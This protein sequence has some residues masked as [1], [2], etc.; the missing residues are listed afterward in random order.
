MSQLKFNMIGIKKIMLKK[1]NYV[2]FEKKDIFHRVLI[3]NRRGHLYFFYK[4]K[5][6]RKNYQSISKQIGAC[7]LTGRSRSIINICYLKRQIFKRICMENKIPM[8]LKKK[9]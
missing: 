9:K 4:L 6:F 7:M 1:R 3:N 2:I 8:L 5:K